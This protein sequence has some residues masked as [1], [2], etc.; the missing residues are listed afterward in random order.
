MKFRGGMNEE[1][2][3]W[4]E[5]LTRG[6]QKRRKW[7]KKMSIAKAK[8]VGDDRAPGRQRE[9]ASNPN[10]MTASSMMTTASIIISIRVPPT[11]IGAFGRR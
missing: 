1:N 3:I 5:D 10:G 9:L 4:E 2:E 7:V 8:I 6:G 11:F